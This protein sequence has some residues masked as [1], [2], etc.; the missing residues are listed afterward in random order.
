MVNSNCPVAIPIYQRLL[1]KYSVYSVS[2]FCKVGVDGYI[3]TVV[4]MVINLGAQLFGFFIIS[5]VC[6]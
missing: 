1:I 2:I 5:K 4:M 6:T 3:G